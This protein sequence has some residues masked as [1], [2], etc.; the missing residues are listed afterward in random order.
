MNS[1]ALPIA[2]LFAVAAAC[3]YFLLGAPS[4]P[5]II[6]LNSPSGTASSGITQPASVAGE[7]STLEK[8]P[9]ESM[10]KPGVNWARLSGLMSA[11]GKS[12]N[13]IPEAT[14]EDIER[15]VAKHGETAANLIAA[16]QNTRDRRWLDRALGLFP[17]SPLVLMEA[18]QA[19]PDGAVKT[20][21][22]DHQPDKERLEIIER[23]KAA[24][25]GNPVPWIFA[26]QELF[27]AKQTEGGIAEIRAAL[28]RPAFYT[29]SNERMDA[30]QRLY[31]S[32]GL[33]PLEAS[34]LA[35]FGITLPHMTA[36][37]Q[38]SRGIMEWQKSAAESGDA[39]AAED[40]LRLTYGLGRM[41]ATPEASRFLVG[42]LVG[43]S[44]EKRVLEALPADAQRDWLPIAPAQ[45]LAEI[46]R[47]KLAVREAAAATDW[48]MQT[49][50]EQL[51]AEW[52][53][54][55]RNEGESGTL[56]WVNARRK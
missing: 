40:A 14:T 24:D 11:D 43:I 19:R 48:V 37:Q 15:F 30:A 25:P 42:Q 52:L 49:R 53:R 16:F 41:F 36:A 27:K 44:M 46:E 32:L 5:T 55:F 50:D 26:A 4:P 12:G 9:G 3:L 33:D 45:R 2:V 10:G 1:R 28:D 51:F 8:V 54:R 23:F 17:N 6:P 20:D 7:T 13:S 18:I 39:A 35:M 31:E 56:N 38:A 21:G 29:F 22:T 34:A 47:Q